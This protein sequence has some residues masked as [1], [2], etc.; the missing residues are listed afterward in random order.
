[1]SHGHLTHKEEPVMFGVPN[2]W[3]T[4]SQ[5]PLCLLAKPY[6]NEKNIEM[7]DNLFEALS[8]VQ[9]NTNKIITFQKL[10]DMFNLI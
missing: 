9:D 5:A 6:R 1:M 10:I 4:Y 8:P 3:R 2:L 7:S